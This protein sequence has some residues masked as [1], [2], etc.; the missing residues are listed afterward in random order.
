M[1]G[2]GEAST[3]L[4]EKQ[5]PGWNSKLARDEQSCCSDK[6]EGWH[7]TRQNL[8][9]SISIHTKLWKSIHTHEALEERLLKGIGRT[10]EKSVFDVITACIRHCHLRPDQ[11]YR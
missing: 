6:S 8:S 1:A 9:S 3:L 11:R 7:T 2:A 5:L 10:H 4:S